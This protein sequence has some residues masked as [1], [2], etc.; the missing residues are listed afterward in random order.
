MFVAAARWLETN[1]DRV[2]SINVFPVPDGDTGTNM[3]LTMR[4][5]IDEAEKAAEGP[6]GEM[7]ATMSHG[8]L[9][10]A[11]GNSGVILSQILRGAARGMAG[12]ET[13]DA[14][15]MAAAL[16]EGSTAAYSAVTNP[17][18]G[19]I[20]TVVRETAEAVSGS[21]GDLITMLESAVAAAGESV[22]RT[23][24]L[25]PVLAEAG[26]VDAGGEGLRVLLDGML[27]YVRG[28]SLD[29]GAEGAGTVESEWLSVL[30]G[31][32]SAEESLYGYCTEVL[33][34]GADL[35]VDAVRNQIVELGDSVLVV[36]DE[37]LVRIHV[38]TDQPGQ[39]LNIGTQTGSLVQVKVDNIRRQAEAFVQMHSASADEAPVIEGQ[40][41]SCVAV[42]SGEGLAALF[43]D[44]GCA[45]VVSGG[46]TMNPSTAEILEAIEACPTEGV[47]VLPNDK[48][49]ILAAEQA[50]PHSNKQVRVVKSRSIPQG[51][52]ALLAFNPD[53]DVDEN[54][55]DMSAALGGVKT[56]EV[57]RAVRSTSIG[58]VKVE[59]GQVIAVVDD[60]L[61]LAAES[62]DAAALQALEDLAADASLL[63][64][65]YGGD[66]TEEQARGLAASLNER[67]PSAEVDVIFGGQPH[68]DYILS[69]E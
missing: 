43:T 17:A 5:A 4:S 44:T 15:A 69:V 31:R 3:Y 37:T 14:A 13:M 41:V 18:E 38:H 47:I 46:P 65:Y 40:T 51:I 52:S 53:Q 7:M 60:V 30:E 62:P 66:S 67:F 58:G 68:Y 61:K 35:D 63:T 42:A 16:R 59:E 28:E 32:H 48:N 25:L 57:T 8:A 19:T 2:N 23:P 50:V 27:R 29:P 49:I 12:Q 55:A 64:V 34:E 56:V 24:E 22:K 21:D 6:A 10:G 33:V 9:M 39:A 54:A 20:L 26:V 11:R 45:H 36:G 1:R